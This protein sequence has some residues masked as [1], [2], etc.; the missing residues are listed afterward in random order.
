[1]RVCRRC[2]E[3][4]F[5]VEEDEHGTFL[6]LTVAGTIIGGVAAAVTGSLVLVPIGAIAGL[7]GDIAVCEVCG[8]DEELYEVMEQE[9]E[10]DD[11]TRFLPHRP[12]DIEMDDTPEVETRGYV[13]DE[14]TNSLVP[15]SEEM[16]VDSGG[17]HISGFDWSIG[18]DSGL[19]DAA[20]GEGGSP[21]AGASSPGSG[22][23][24]GTAGA[25]GVG[26]TGGAAGGG[27]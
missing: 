11:R 17:A 1:M 19:G 14:A 22:A 25:G 23:S 27:A 3:D 26:G 12:P 15:A 9:A 2:M 16:A 13:L 7:G 24:G 6:G 4:I 21:S 5:D 10:R 20:C 18:S 8:A